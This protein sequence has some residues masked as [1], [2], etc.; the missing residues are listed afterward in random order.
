MGVEGEQWTRQ[1]RRRYVR[2]RVA[3]EVTRCRTKKF[4][5]NRHKITKITSE[6]RINSACAYLAR[7]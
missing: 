6:K 3:E 2:W 7:K 5:N 4:P 1:N